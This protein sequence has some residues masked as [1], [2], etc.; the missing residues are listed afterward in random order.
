MEVDVECLSRSRQRFSELAGRPE[1]LPAGE[2]DQ[3]AFVVPGAVDGGAEGLVGQGRLA[4]L[5]RSP[6]E[7]HRGE[8]LLVGEQLRLLLA[9]QAT[10]GLAA[11]RVRGRSPGARQVVGTRA[12]LRDLQLA[13]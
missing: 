9:Q 4:H 1:E 2:A 6:G 12:H 3:T 8:R 10:N 11:E 7:P 5:V 13:A